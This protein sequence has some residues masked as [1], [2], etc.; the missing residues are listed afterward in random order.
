MKIRAPLVHS[1]RS[2]VSNLALLLPE[3]TATRLRKKTGRHVS[4]STITSWLHEHRQ[5]CMY[6]RLR[7]D[8]LRALHADERSVTVAIEVPIWLTEVDIASLE[9]EHGIEL[10]PCREGV[11]R[12]ITGHVDFLQVRNG[13]GHILDYKPDARTNKPIAQLAIYA[14]ALTRQALRHQVRAVQR[15]GVLRILPPDHCLQPAPSSGKKFPRGRSSIK[16]ACVGCS[17]GFA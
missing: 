6:R 16:F 14:L 3:M 10:A 9:K 13:A 2:Y 17:V 12:A 4:P 11:E 5:R 15:G 8:G 7:A 1:G